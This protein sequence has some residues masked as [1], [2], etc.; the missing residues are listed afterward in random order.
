MNKNTK[1]YFGDKRLNVV[2]NRKGQFKRAGKHLGAVLTV[3]AI[4][5]ATYWFGWVMSTEEIIKE[6]EV[7]K[8]VAVHAP[9]MDRIANC[10]SGNK[11]FDKNGQVLMRGNTNR[12]VDLGVYQINTVW[13]A[14]ATKQGYDLTKETDNRAYAH[15]LY[16]KYGTEP[17][18]SSKKCWNK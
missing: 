8:E 15:Y 4:L 14:D 18:Y 1:V 9:V 5:F 7:V 13:F 3:V 16:G 12:T 17:W 11:H 10:E 6:V 2:R